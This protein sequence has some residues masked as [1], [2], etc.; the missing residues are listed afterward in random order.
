MPSGTVVR[1]TTGKTVIGRPSQK[2]RS[3]VAILGATGS[4]GSSAIDVCRHLSDRFEIHSLTAVTSW[5]KLA[6][7][8]L[9]I[10]PKIVALNDKSTSENLSE[11]LRALRDALLGTGIE[12]VTGPHAM[13]QIV[14]RN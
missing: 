4:I 2:Q 12:V 7:S 1:E 5:K 13:E 6:E 9:D 8:A 11:N 14:T 10:R 3:R